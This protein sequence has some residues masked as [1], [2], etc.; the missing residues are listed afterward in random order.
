MYVSKSIHEF[1]MFNMIRSTDVSV[2]NRLAYLNSQ[3]QNNI[4]KSADLKF[5]LLYY[6]L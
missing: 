6:K 2:Y 1:Y 3:K 5:I 4:Q